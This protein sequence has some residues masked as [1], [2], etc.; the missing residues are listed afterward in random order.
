MSVRERALTAIE[1]LGPP[2]DH[3]KPDVEPPVRVGVHFKVQAYTEVG[4]D[5]VPTEVLW[6][7]GEV[8]RFT[9]PE[10]SQQNRCRAKEAV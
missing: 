6:R 2:S 8:D 4:Q 9:N 10:I 1:V 7:H 3:R 5:L